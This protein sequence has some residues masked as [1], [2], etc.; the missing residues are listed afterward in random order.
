METLFASST[1]W[2]AAYEFYCQQRVYFGKDAVIFPSKEFRE[3]FDQGKRLVKEIDIRDGHDSSVKSEK[4]E[5]TEPKSKPREK[6]MI[7]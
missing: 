6:G 4:D 5:T 2:K 3:L 7:F 1:P